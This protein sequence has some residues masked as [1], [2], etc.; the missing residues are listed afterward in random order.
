MYATRVDLE[1]RF[2]AD[3]IANLEAMQT[4]QGALEEAL[5]DATEE[6]DSYVAVAYTLPLPE[7]PSTLKRVACNI[8]RYRLY[9][10]QPTE[11]ITNRYE[12]EVSYLKRIADKKAVLPIKNEQDQPTGELPL[13]SPATMP[14]GTTYK[15]GVFGDAVLDMMPSIK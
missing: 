5:Q 14:I 8:A 12:A 4:I 13:Q 2:G 9:F 10:Q 15:G 1:K 3:E 7:I 6:I 11:E